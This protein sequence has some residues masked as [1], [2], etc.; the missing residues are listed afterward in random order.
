[1]WLIVACVL[2]D[3]L[4]YQTMERRRRGAHAYS[5]RRRWKRRGA[6]KPSVRV[7]IGAGRTCVFARDLLTKQQRRGANGGNNW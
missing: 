7:R 5:L 6:D 3:L 4:R 1:M 2:A